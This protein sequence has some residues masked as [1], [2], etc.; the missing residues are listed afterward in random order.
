[1]SALER[2]VET[3]LGAREQTRNGA[4]LFGRSCQLLQPRVV[5]TLG[6]DLTLECNRG[7][8]RAIVVAELDGSARLHATR[9]HALFLAEQCRKEPRVT[10]RVARADQLLG[11]C[12]VALFKTSDVGERAFYRPVLHRSVALFE[13]A[14]PQCGCRACSHFV[15]SLGIRTL[16]IR[17]RGCVG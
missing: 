3:D 13:G 5:D 17:Q 10:T 11:I 16:T 8:L 12:S 15:N 7:D 9:G 4:L 1:S 14:V 6:L 2:C